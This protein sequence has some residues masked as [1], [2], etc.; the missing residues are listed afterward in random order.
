M[1]R[2]A[3]AIALVA[4]CACATNPKPVADQPL[5][6]TCAEVAKQLENGSQV[7]PTDRKDVVESLKGLTFHWRLRVLSISDEISR[8]ELANGMALNV[9]CLDRPGTTKEG[10]R[11]IF[12]LYF[13]RQIAELAA[14]GRGATLTVD[15]MMMSYEGQGAFA[16]K[17]KAYAI[18]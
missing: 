2:L 17:A 16:A 7:A 18:E 5:S 15:G 3:P 10:M 6:M 11:Y 12:T 13:E 9:E 14:L 1:H 4:L 8:A